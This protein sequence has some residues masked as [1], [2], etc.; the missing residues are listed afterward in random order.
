M[1]SSNAPIS[2]IPRDELRIIDLTVRMFVEPALSLDRPRLQAYLDRTRAEKEA[3]LQSLS[4]TKADLQSSE[5]FAAL[6]RQL[7]VEPPT[8]ASP[9][10]PEK[11]IY[12]FAKTDKAM[13]ELSEHTDGRV[14]A[15]VAA[16]LGSKSTIGE[17]RAA[18][19]LN[20]HARGPLC[21]YINYC[22]AHTLR[23]SGGDS[24]NFQNLTRITHGPGGVVV[25]GPAQRGELRLS[26]MAPEGSQIVVVDAS[27]IECRLVNGLAGQDDVLDKFR[28]KEDIYSQLATRFYGEPVDKS[29]PEKRGTGKQIE[30]SCGFRAGAGSIKETARRGTY[31]PPVILTDEQALAARNLYR[32][33]H[34]RVVEL[35]KYGDKIVL[36]ALLRGGADF[37]WGP[38]R[39][40][41]SRIYVPGGAWLDYAHLRFGIY[42]DAKG[43]ER[44]GFYTE[45]RRG[46]KGMHG[47]IIVQNVVEGLARTILMAAALQ[48][49]PRYKIVMR[50]HDEL[51][52]LARTGEAPEALAFGLQVMKTPPAWMPHLPLEAEGG[53]DVRY[54]K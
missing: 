35:W 41:G 24:L 20:M 45:S 40:C 15:L 49:M 21:V 25:E 47:G 7:G 2:I 4:V 31:G 23:D 27:Q 51:A 33:T 44:E 30:L 38:L 9:K 50:T 13:E 46:K 52:Y 5:K 6:L 54:S 18:G 28:N 26:L 1:E 32:S 42:V 37:M 36:P 53:Y 14:A 39:V 29:K 22:G 19:L 8:K 17:T 34:P 10:H 12:A 16:R 48:I 11:K 3:A 43:E